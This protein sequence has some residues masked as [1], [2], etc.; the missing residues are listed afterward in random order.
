MLDRSLA[1]VRHGARPHAGSDPMV[2]SSALLVLSLSWCCS[3]CAGHQRPSASAQPAPAHVALVAPPSAALDDGPSQA[4]P[5]L[6]SISMALHLYAAPPPAGLLARVGTGPAWPES[7]HLP[8]PRRVVGRTFGSGRSRCHLAL[9]LGAHLGDP[10]WAAERGI[11]A[12]QGPFRTGGQVVMIVHPGGWVTAYAHLSVILVRAGDTVRRGQQ[13][14]RAGST[15][16]SRGPHLHFVLLVD[17]HPADPLPM[18]EPRPSFV[19]P[20][21]RFASAEKAAEAWR[22]CPP[23]GQ[24]Y[25]GPVTEAPRTPAAEGSD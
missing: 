1:A 17:G 18:L 22:G 6:G 24:R 25:E 23:R 3:A 13:I 21:R 4:E 12:Y 20:G 11:V 8:S 10:V 15:G 5:P 16:N 14:A 2:R 7:L 9:D 19:A